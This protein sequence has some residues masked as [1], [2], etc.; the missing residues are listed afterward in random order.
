MSPELYC[1]PARREFEVSGWGAA[2]VCEVLSTSH[3]MFRRVSNDNMQVLV[4]QFCSYVVQKCAGD[5]SISVSLVILLLEHS[6]W[7][8]QTCHLS[9]DVSTVTRQGST[10]VL[11]ISWPQKQHGP[12]STCFTSPFIKHLPVQ[13]LV[14]H[15]SRI[16]ESTPFRKE[17]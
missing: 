6:A 3:L 9:L 10:S 11:S 2:E 5:R 4:A 15:K 16:A 12:H 8:T 13:L 14:L 1:L 17:C 7:Q